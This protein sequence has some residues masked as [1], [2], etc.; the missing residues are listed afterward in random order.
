MM[1]KELKRRWGYLWR[2]RQ[3]DLEL[4]E[5][6][7][8]HIQ[9]R[10]EELVEAGLPERDARAQAQREFGP[11]T[12][13][14]E[15][16]R[17][18]W[19]F[20]L[21]EDFLADLKY[22]GR[23]LLRNPAFAGAAVLSLTLGIGANL[24]IFSLTTE[25]LF[26]P[27]SV[28]DAQSLTY[29]ILGGNSNAAPAQYRFLRDAHLFEGVA[30]MNPE[31]ETNWRYGEDTHRVWGTRVTD[32]FFDVT[33]VRVALG[34][35]IHTGDQWEAVLSYGFWKGRLGG[36]PRILGRSLAFDGGLY[37]VVGVLPPEHRTLIGFGFSPDLYLTINPA[38]GGKETTVMLYA[39]LPAYA[40]RESLY[41]RLLAVCRDLDRVFPRAEG[42]WSNNTEMRGVAGLERLKLLSGMP[43][44]AFFAVLMAVVGIVFLIACAN[45]ASLL[46][47]RAASRHHELAIRQSIGASRWRIVR[48]LLAESLLMAILGTAAALALNLAISALA[49]RIRL[50]LPVPI[51]LQIQPDWRVLCYA[52]SLAMASALVCGFM[53]ALKATRRD[54]QAALKLGE[55]SIAARLGFRRVLVIAQLTASVMLLL[56]GFLFLRNL[57]LANSLSPGFD[58]D[59]TVWAYMRL[60]PER[61]ASKDPGVSKNKIGSV[62]YRALEQLRALPA[63]ES[64]AAAAIVPLND[65]L[66]FGGDVLI[67]SR[68]Q[69]Q[70]LFYTGNWISAEYFKTMGIPLLSGRDFLPGDRDGAPRVVVLNQAMA[71]R[72]F[73][74]QN[75]VGHTLRFH[76]DPPASVVGVVS[77]SKYF[78]LGEKDLPAVFWPYAQSSRAAV[79]LNFLVRSQHPESILK[80]VNRALGKLDSTAAIEVKPMTRALGLALLPSRVGAGLLGSMGLLGLLLASVGLYGVL[81]YSVTSRIRE[82]GIRVAL[83]AKPIAIGYMV[84]R[85]SLLL[86]GAGLTAGGVLSYFAVN[87]LALFLVPE[88]SPHDPVSLIAVFATL[89][90]VAMAATLLPVI[91]ALRVDPI[92]AL[93]YE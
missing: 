50:P 44:A 82:I 19:Q 25:F 83:G 66:K 14:R 59:H 74:A 26:S 47:A 48:Q 37:T 64:A 63:V 7:R 73:G 13:L 41:P 79:N 86:V 84:L 57:L 71:R 18:A 9:T 90:L 52:A 3:F 34:R 12:R 75:P 1:W 61:Y 35:P 78:S 23:A 40:T 38:T 43:I 67:D 2:R 31:T 65:N 89:L 91:R 24:A 53:P 69:L 49:N 88:L 85:S 11:Q 46:L 70:R 33:G 21:L 93:R 39:R 27:P 62:S 30:G 16:S 60:V 29:V 20:I 55:R 5:E 6:I 92:V 58:I 22:A 15:D 10:T 4:A 87:P 36:D 76:D 51:R 68:T 54:I 17:A 80:E 77:D 8:F 32:N 56:T 42:E 72:L 28:R 81:M 45:V